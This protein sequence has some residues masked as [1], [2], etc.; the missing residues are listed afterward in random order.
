MIPL[1]FIDLKAGYP[2]YRLKLDGLQQLL[3]GASSGLDDLR[4][5]KHQ[6]FVL[7]A[8]PEPAPPE[9]ASVMGAS[10]CVDL[11]RDGIRRRCSWPAG[12]AVVRRLARGSGTVVPRVPIGGTTRRRRRWVAWPLR[13]VRWARS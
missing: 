4:R 1:P 11:P 6:P 7:H 12:G 10:P 13:R 9:L 2:I 8:G 5:S 3:P